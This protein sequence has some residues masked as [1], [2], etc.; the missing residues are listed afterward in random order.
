MATQSKT[1]FLAEKA[2]N[3]RTLLAGFAP[4]AEA[5][6]WMSAFDEKLLLPTI[7]LYLVPL[8]KAGKLEATAMEVLKHLTIP[9]DRVPD[10]RARMIKY[11]QCFVEVAQA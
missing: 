8:H 10:I 1:E 11:F 6:K 4:D 7:L 9:E 3:L 2:K 5:S